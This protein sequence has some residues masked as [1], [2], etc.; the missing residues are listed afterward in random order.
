MHFALGETR[1][2]DWLQRLRDA[3]KSAHQRIERSVRFL[4]EGASADG[5]R[6][7]LALLYGFIA[8]LERE[9][10]A[11]F[12]GVDPLE[13]PARQKR[14]LLEADLRALGVEEPLDLP[15]CARLPR[16]DSLQ[17]ALGCLYVLEG[18][19]LGG[20]YLERKLRQL[21]PDAIA[22]AHAYFSCYG[23]ATGERWKAFCA[24]LE[25]LGDEERERE[26][27]DAAC[28]TFARLDDWLND[29][30]AEAVT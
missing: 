5:Y 15:I 17:R 11:R 22:R 3:T 30:S 27:L 7:H 16:I 25:T 23:P 24:A 4:D 9:L 21:Q 2:P 6:A 28:E 19:T 14:A 12:G 20:R 1:G 13:L 29:G 18:S 10:L 26:L 8:P